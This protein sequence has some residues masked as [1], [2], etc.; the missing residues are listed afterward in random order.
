MS[1]KSATTILTFILF[2][3]DSWISRHRPFKEKA[4]EEEENMNT[5][6]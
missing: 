2:F 3:S 1:M 6:Q 5:R 4:E